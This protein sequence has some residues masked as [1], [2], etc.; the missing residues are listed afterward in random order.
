M[1]RYFDLPNPIFGIDSEMEPLTLDD[2]EIEKLGFG[3]RKEEV[4]KSPMDFAPY[5]NNNVVAMIR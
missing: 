4:E 1:W 5:S 3:I 2:F